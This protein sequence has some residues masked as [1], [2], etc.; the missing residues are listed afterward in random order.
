MLAIVVGFAV[1]CAAV[2]AALIVLAI[3]IALQA[4]A[5]KQR[6]TVPALSALR[7]KALSAR[8]DLKRIE[9]ALREI[10]PVRERAAI[11]GASILFS[12]A[13]YR[14]LLARLGL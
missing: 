4:R 12:V 13:K 11:A 2:Y 6:D 7:E 5:L 9:D 1:A 14:A 8:F 3:R 10:A